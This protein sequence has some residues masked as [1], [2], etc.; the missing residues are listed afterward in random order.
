M[1]QN[2]LYP[3]FLKL[4]NLKTL[5]IG[6]G[7]VGLEK[8]ESIITNSPTAAITIVAPFIKEEIFEYAVTHKNIQIVQRKFKDK[9]LNGFNIAIGATD[10]KVLHQDI[11]IKANTLNILVNIAD[12]PHLC[13]FYLG[14]IMKKGNL[15]IAISTNG[16]SPTIAKRMKEILIETIPLEINSL[17]DNMQSI[18]NKLNL[19]FGEK[20]KHLN[21][22]TKT[23]S[24]QK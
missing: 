16:K 20:V 2:N 18:R 17:L 3:I 24:E 6:G 22:V 5:I 10:D 15:K 7:N 1:E 11:K 21:E 23:L 4:E 9:D 12:T 13:D 19:S 14:S 8:L